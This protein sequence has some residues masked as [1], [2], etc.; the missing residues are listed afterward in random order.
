MAGYESCVRSAEMSEE[1][2]Q[3]R[4]WLALFGLTIDTR[5]RG[6]QGKETAAQDGVGYDVVD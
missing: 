6:R 1:K 4:A 2:L 3:W 5:T